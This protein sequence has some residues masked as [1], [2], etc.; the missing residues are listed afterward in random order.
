MRWEFQLMLFY[1]LG[2]AVLLLVGGFVAD[3]LEQRHLR[4][5]RDKSQHKVYW[6]NYD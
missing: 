5:Q 1:C 6:A 4:K 3:Y 2:W